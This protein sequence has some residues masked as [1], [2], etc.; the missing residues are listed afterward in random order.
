MRD[1]RSKFLFPYFNGFLIF[2]VRLC[3]RLLLLQE[4]CDRRLSL[5]ENR[6]AIALYHYNKI[7]MRSLPKNL[8]EQSQFSIR[9]K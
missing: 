1:N 5:Q 9:K 8:Q 3:D 6:N 2:S 7:G 4:K